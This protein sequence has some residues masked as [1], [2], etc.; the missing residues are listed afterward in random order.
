M[1]P[2]EKVQ[3]MYGAFARGDVP[4][5]LADLAEDV[6]WEYNAF[7]NPVPWLQ[8]LKGRANAVRFFEALGAIDLAQFEPRHFFADGKFVVVLIDVDFTVKATGK[9]VVEAEAVHLWHFNADGRVARFR[10]RVDTW[11]VAQ[12]LKGD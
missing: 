9:R 8:P 5:I 6:E 2:I 11:Q 7:P 12:A 3:Q 1:T 10:H 4:A